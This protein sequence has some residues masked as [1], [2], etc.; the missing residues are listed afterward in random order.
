MKKRSNVLFVILGTILFIASM[1]TSKAPVLIKANGEQVNTTAR[2]RLINEGFETGDLSGWTR[3]SLWK[4]ESGMRAFD[5]SLVHGY[6]YF[7]GNNPYNRDGNYSIG[8]TSQANKDD[9]PV[10]WD[11]STERMGYLRSSNFILGGSG[12]I[13]FKI[14]GGRAPSFAFVSVRRVIDDYEVARFGNR[15]FNNT[16]IATTQYG[17]SISNA[18]AFLF[19]YYFDLTS[20]DD[21]N[22]GD[23]LYFVLNDISGYDWS[24]LSAD[25]FYTYLPDAP[26]PDEDELAINIL[27]TVLGIDTAD[28]SIKNGKFDTD[29]SDWTV[30]NDTEKGWYW[31]GNKYAKSNDGG[32]GDTGILRSSAF[33]LDEHK[34]LKFD[35]AGGFKHDKQIFVSIREVNT[36]IEKLR[37]VSRKGD[38]TESFSEHICD[39]S[40]L[41]DSQKYYVEFADAR[42]GGWGIFY[43]DN[44][45]L[46]SS[47]DSSKRAPSISGLPLNFDLTPVQE[48]DNYGAYFLEE[49]GPY[50]ETLDGDQVDWSFLS[51]EYSLLSDD[52][53]DAFVDSEASGNIKDARDR[54][55]FLYGKYGTAQGWD[56]FVK[57]SSN[58]PY[59]SSSINIDSPINQKDLI[60]KVSY[61]LVVVIA[62]VVVTGAL[63]NSRRK[64]RINFKN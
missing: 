63:Y 43:A 58:N 47:D 52:A 24:I 25:S 29:L 33:T 21:V 12:W 23:E 3:F 34:L 51:S 15:H 7:S 20:L 38:E 11:Q 16:T 62:L 22:L 57:D 14:G 17:S 49:T 54:F 60:F 37:F 53:K 61:V 10:K 45:R 36:N 5:P 39:L 64:K 6:T 13:S 28:N 56:Y 48:A 8:V 35:W 32:D 46:S 31:S 55:L 9:G 26:E 2:N 27:P 18:E 30:Q 42:T 40:S 44:V 59:L 1:G 4:N 19:Q 50:C 41:D